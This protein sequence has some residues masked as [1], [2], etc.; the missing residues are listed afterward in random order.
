MQGQNREPIGIVVLSESTVKD[1][2]A[3]TV[4]AWHMPG[5]RHRQ[6]GKKAEF[7]INAMRYGAGTATSRVN[8]LRPVIS[9][10]VSAGGN[11]RAAQQAQESR[12]EISSSQMDTPLRVVADQCVGRSIWAPSPAEPNA[13]TRG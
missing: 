10:Q 9:D 3:I 1:H 12:A 11:S 8:S 4:L 6:I 2:Q 5:G 13:E 7:W